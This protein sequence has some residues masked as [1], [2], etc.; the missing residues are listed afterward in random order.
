[1][2]KLKLRFPFAL[3]SGVP[4]LLAVPLC[5]ALVFQAVAG[6]ELVLP[7][8]GPVRGKPFANP[9]EVQPDP[10]TSARPILARNMFAPAAAPAK[11]GDA[12]QGPLGAYSIVG[13]IEIGRTPFAIV[14]APGLR[15]LQVRTGARFG[16]WRIR[17]IA[18][19]EVRLARGAERLS[20]RFGPTGPVAISAPQERE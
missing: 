20:V 8:A 4:L 14:Q 10:V 6:N 9:A 5:A 3:P 15:I 18:R 13:S 17:S 1:M 11:A 19:D 16:G 12:G 2:L 7:L